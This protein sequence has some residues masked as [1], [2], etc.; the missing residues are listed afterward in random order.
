MIFKENDDYKTLVNK[1]SKLRNLVV[2]ASDKLNEVSS[3][4]KEK[5]KDFDEEKA[6]ILK[7]LDQISSN[8]KKYAQCYKCF[9]ILDEQYTKLQIDYNHNYNVMR[10]YQET[11]RY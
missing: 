4:L 8:Y 1:N 3:Q 2:Q 7:E 9:S 11:L 5:E 10:S 6:T